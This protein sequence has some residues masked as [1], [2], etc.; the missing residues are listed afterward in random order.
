MSEPILPPEEVDADPVDDAAL[1]RRWD[2]LSRQSLEVDAA[3][4][5]TVTCP[6]GRLVRLIE[7]FR[8]RVCS[9]VLC[10]R[11]ALRHFGLR[12]GA[13]GKI[14]RVPEAE[15]GRVLGSDS[16]RRPL[17]YDPSAL[18]TCATEPAEPTP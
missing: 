11:C 6:C 7:A 5:I 8:C 15:A 12:R 14:E 4:G 2:V 1:E 9:I 16:N 13:D 10:A 17:G 3:R 18:T